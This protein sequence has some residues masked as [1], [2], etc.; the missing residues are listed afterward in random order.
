MVSDYGSAIYIYEQ[1]DTETE[2]VG[3]RF[4]GN[5]A[6]TKAGAIM[7]E[8]AGTVLLRNNSFTSNSVADPSWR[9]ADG[10]AI[11]YKCDPATAGDKYD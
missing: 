10:G 5:S 2:I 11:Y 9:Y 3:C 1:M 6:Y 8:Q 4:T 7:F